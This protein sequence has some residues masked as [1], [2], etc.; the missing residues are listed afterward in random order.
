MRFVFAIQHDFIV[1]V[2]TSFTSSSPVSNSQ[3]MLQLIDLCFS[4][5]LM[6][7]TMVSHLLLVPDIARGLQAFFSDFLCDLWKILVQ[8]PI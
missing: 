6:D 5:L 7:S 2:F 3:Q 8:I 4:A 1:T